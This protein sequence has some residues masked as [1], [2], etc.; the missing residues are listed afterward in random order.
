MNDSEK[1]DAMRALNEI[2]NE[3]RDIAG[4][5]LVAVLDEATY[6]ERGDRLAQLTE[7]L[8]ERLR[9]GERLPDPWDN[10]L[11]RAQ[12][13]RRERETIMPNIPPLL[14][15][16][17]RVALNA[18]RLPGHL[19]ELQ[20]KAEEIID[21]A[22]SARSPGPRTQLPRR[23]LCYRCVA[24]ATEGQVVHEAMTIVNGNAV[25]HEHI[26]NRAEHIANRGGPKC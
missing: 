26:A 10:A 7:W 9:N 5:M 4:E 3:V 21:F 24:D 20:D 25:C 16:E 15:A 23:L 14:L 1:K 6:R 22:D 12:R 19:Q 17:L 11:V 8:D 2:L 13:G 18:S